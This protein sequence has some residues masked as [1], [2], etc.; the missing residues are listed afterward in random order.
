MSMAVNLVSK[1]A[2]GVSLGPPNR[3]ADPTIS[4]LSHQYQAFVIYSGHALTMI[5]VWRLR[6]VSTKNLSVCPCTNGLI[7]DELRRIWVFSITRTRDHATVFLEGGTMTLF[8]SPVWMAKS[9]MAATTPSAVN[10][11]TSF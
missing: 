5:P 6:R 9:T 1:G 11:V 2:E 7:Y 3:S 8:S 10:P 4:L